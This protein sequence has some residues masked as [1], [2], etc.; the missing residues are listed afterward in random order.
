M[1]HAGRDGRTHN[2]GERKQSDRED[3]ERAFLGESCQ[4]AFYLAKPFGPS[5]RREKRKHEQQNEERAIKE[6]VWTIVREE[7]TGRPFIG[8][9]DYRIRR[10]SIRRLL[11]TS[12][13]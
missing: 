7:P 10:H 5:M 12:F 1:S 2:D 9:G 11:R 3:G 13:V 8:K 6:N 4:W